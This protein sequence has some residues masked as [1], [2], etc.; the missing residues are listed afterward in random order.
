[1]AVQ[2]VLGVIVAPPLAGAL[3]YEANQFFRKENLGSKIAL[4][5]LSTLA[6]VGA[7]IYRVYGENTIVSKMSTLHVGIT[8]A[9][10]FF[11]SYMTIKAALDFK[12][13][14]SS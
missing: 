8:G 1:M 2:F 3:V 12:Q 13:H 10:V 7:S 9:A 5:V 14:M 4:L 11:A 6:G